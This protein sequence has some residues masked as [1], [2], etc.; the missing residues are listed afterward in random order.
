M[1]LR[2]KLG[3]AEGRIGVSE[4]RVGAF[5]GRVR[6]SGFNLSDCPFLSPAAQSV[7]ICGQTIGLSVTLKLFPPLFALLLPHCV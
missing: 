7:L 3:A 5:E 1:C 4:G 6:A 2:G